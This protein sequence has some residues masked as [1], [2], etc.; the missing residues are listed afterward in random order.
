VGDIWAST[1]AWEKGSWFSEVGL[2][3]GQLRGETAYDS[4]GGRLRGR[5]ALSHTQLRVRAGRTLV[6]GDLRLTPSLSGFAGWQRQG[7][8]RRDS[9]VLRAEAP[10]FTQPYRGVESALDVHT[11]WQR[12][13]ALQWRP[14][15]R[16]EATHTRSYGPAHLRV[17]QADHAGVLGFVTQEGVAGLPRWA[18]R[19]QLGVTLRGQ[20]QENW[21]LRL[22]YAGAWA[23]QTSG[24]AGH[25]ALAV[26][27]MRF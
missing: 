11:D 21:R 12:T 3:G 15:V 25:A 20:R 26:F 17:H 2:A 22:G 7:A 4:V 9:A 16:M 27:S 23:S 10:G 18:Y 24:Q 19:L 5:L 13:R 1:L 8:Q 6:L 14:E